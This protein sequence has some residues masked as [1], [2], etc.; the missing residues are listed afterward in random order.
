MDTISIVIPVYNE[1]AVLP[2]LFSALAGTFASR[3]DL[4]FEVI[5]VNDGSRDR[6]WAMLK[7]QAS[8]D[9]RFKAVNLSRNFGH[10]LALTAGL[11]RASGDAVVA[12]DADLQDT[13]EVMLEMVNAWK[14][15]HDIV[16]GKRRARAGESRFKLF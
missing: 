10:Q 14:S 5:L 13:P 3:P 6:T 16:Y 1:E 4:A 8:R 7:E 12:M 11:D 9:P 15:G 2:Q